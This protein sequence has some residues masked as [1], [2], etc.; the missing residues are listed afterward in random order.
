MT[1]SRDLLSVK[2]AAYQIVCSSISQR[3]LHFPGGDH[4]SVR[5][6][7]DRVFLN[8]I[9]FFSLKVF[10]L[11]RYA[12][13]FIVDEFLMSVGGAAN[14]SAYDVGGIGKESRSVAPCLKKAR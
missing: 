4:A 1:E 5:N 3:P 7:F 14:F 6:G 12:Q 13:I 9:T 11:R 8:L 2:G 10:H